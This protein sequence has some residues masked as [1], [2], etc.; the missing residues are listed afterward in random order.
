MRFLW[1]SCKPSYFGNW[2]LRLHM[3]KPLRPIMKKNE[4][5]KKSYVI[6]PSYK[7]LIIIKIKMEIKIKENIYIYVYILQTQMKSDHIR[8]WPL[9]PNHQI[10]NMWSFICPIFFRTYAQKKGCEKKKNSKIPKIRNKIP[11]F[12]HKQIW[13]I[14]KK[15]TTP[16]SISASFTVW[17]L[18]ETNFGCRIVCGPSLNHFQLI[19]GDVVPWSWYK[20][21][22]PFG[23]IISLAYQVQACEILTSWTT[24][25]N[26]N[27]LNYLL[28]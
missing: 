6:Q 1:I 13:N 7:K 16:S 21:P 24:K 19:E 17:V 20:S 25:P 23:G 15:N 18:L 22:R 10:R 9:Y 26:S 27:M 2:K 14:N 8:K 4:K 5:V 3:R 28:V 12:V 11:I